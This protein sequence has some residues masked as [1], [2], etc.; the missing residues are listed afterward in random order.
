[1]LHFTSGKS[2]EG[3]ALYTDLLSLINSTQMTGAGKEVQVSLIA[4]MSALYHEL[5]CF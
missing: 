3:T 1:M 5:N 4:T 2:C